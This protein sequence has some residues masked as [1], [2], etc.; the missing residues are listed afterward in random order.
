MGGTLSLNQRRLYGERV[1]TVM[2]PPLAL[3][4]NGV[5]DDDDCGGDATMTVV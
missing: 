3:D 4:A 5:G 1:D 2:V